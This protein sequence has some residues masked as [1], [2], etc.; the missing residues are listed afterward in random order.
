G[1]VIEDRLVTLADIDRPILTFVGEVD[2][3]APARAVRALNLAAP[4]ADIYEVS[5]RAG[6]FGLVVG[7]SAARA[8][9]PVV[10]AWAHW[11]DGE[12]ELP[13]EVR[14]VAEAPLPADDGAG[15]TAARIG[16]GL[17]LAANVGLGIARS[18]A[19]TAL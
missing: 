10:A 4:G 8:T 2:E 18:L 12:G 11:G 16:Y 5:L 9:W 19:G 1:F 14:H 17:P 6:H 3:I 7:S 15:R 13:P